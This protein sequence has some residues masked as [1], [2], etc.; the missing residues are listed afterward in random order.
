MNSFYTEEEQKSIGFKSL[1]KDVLISRKT[2]IYSPQLISIGDNV[3]IDDFCVLSGEITIGSNI[4][5][6]SHCGLY[7]AKGI[8]LEDYSGLSSR[9]FI[10][11][12]MDDF[13]GKYL[14]G[15]NQKDST[16]NIEGGLVRIKKYAVIGTNST[17]FPDI[18][19]EEGAVIGAHSLVNR[20]IK[21]WSINAGYPI[22]Y[23]G[24]RSR[25]LLNLID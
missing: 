16:T 25:E 14:V 19:I 21:E 9:V 20:N 3:R 8:I 12:A 2:S 18:T 6:A 4:H 24:D 13:S 22:R 5:I 17:V 15:P 23:F 1:G 7:G 10:Y 11:S